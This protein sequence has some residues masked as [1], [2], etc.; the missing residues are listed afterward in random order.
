MKLIYSP[1]DGTIGRK[2]LQSEKNGFI[3]SSFV[4][5]ELMNNDIFENSINLVIFLQVAVIYLE[6]IT[7]SV[8]QKCCKIEPGTYFLSELTLLALFFFGNLSRLKED[9]RKRRGRL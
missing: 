5:C 2:K 3:L 6:S 7:I 4:S 9:N 1:L 8:Q